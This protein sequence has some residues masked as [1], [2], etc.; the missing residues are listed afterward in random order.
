[1]ICFISFG[2]RFFEHRFSIV[3]GSMLNEF[4]DRSFGENLIITAA[5]CAKTKDDQV[6]ELFRF[7][8]DCPSI[9]DYVLSFLKHF[10]IIFNIFTTPL[11]SG[12]PFYHFLT[13]HFSTSIV[14]SIS[15]GLRMHFGSMMDQLCVIF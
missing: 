11:S 7:F 14:G 6:P 2:L 3:Y 5:V 12:R 9:L 15:N 1:M 4:V 13:V 10:D 8:N